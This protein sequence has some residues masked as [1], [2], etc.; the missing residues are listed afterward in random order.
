MNRRYQRGVP[1]GHQA[2]DVEDLP[3][4]TRDPKVIAQQGFSGSRSEKD[5][6]LWG[7]RVQFSQDPWPARLHLGAAGGLVDTAFAALIGGELEVLH[8]VGQIELVAVDLG[9]GQGFVQEAAGRADEGLSCPVLLVTRLLA[10]Q[11]H[12]RG[13][14]SGPENSLS[15]VAI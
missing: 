3:S 12:P 15:G 10:D 14:S 11:H 13:R 7:N 5:H 2:R 6:D 8:G 1:A 9:S 4:V